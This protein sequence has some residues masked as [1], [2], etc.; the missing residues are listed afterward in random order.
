MGPKRSTNERVKIGDSVRCEQHHGVMRCAGTVYL[1]SQA[2]VD[3]YN[4]G[5]TAD[6]GKPH[7]PASFEA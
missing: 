2:D 1:T 4:D 7:R 3:A 5:K 6:C